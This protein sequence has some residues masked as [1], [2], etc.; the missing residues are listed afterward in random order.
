VERTFFWFACNRRRATEFE[1][2]AETLAT[3]VTVAS[4][5]LPLWRIVREW[6]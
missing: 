6:S 4:I 1:N 2:L 3:F 5:Q